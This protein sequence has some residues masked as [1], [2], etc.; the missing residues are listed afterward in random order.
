MKL[1]MAS[2]PLKPLGVLD[3]L[4]AATTALEWVLAEGDVKKI[5][6]MKR[7]T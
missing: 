3:Q 4:Q 7:S 5:D 1:S 6:L 2:E